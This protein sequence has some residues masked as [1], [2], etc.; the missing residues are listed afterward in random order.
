[1]VF[2]KGKILNLLFVS[3]YVKESQGKHFFHPHKFS[4]EFFRITL[5][6]PQSFYKKFSRKKSKTLEGKHISRYNEFLF[7]YRTK[8]VLES[9]IRNKNR[10]KY[11][12]FSPLYFQKRAG[13]YG[14]KE[15]VF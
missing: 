14:R 15:I 1:M 5:S 7:P 3:K 12:D 10:A 9:S 13:L 6:K 2:V 11:R 4:G 8:I